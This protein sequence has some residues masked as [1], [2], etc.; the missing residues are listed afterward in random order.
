MDSLA[1]SHRCFGLSPGR[2]PSIRI[3]SQF[4]PANS[5]L[6]DYMNVLLKVLLS[7]FLDGSDVIMIRVVQIC[8]YLKPA[9]AKYRRACLELANSEMRS[10]FRKLGKI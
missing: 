5:N 10:G 4:S 6:T 2:F 7:L 3:L 8:E 1:S 9:Q